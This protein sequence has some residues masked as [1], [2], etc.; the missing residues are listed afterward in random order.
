M[1]RLM[2]A[3]LDTEVGER[4]VGLSGGQA[5]RVALARAVLADRELLLLDEPT[6]QVD[7]ASEAA[8]V[9]ALAAIGAGRTV[10]T[11]SHRAGALIAAN[12]LVRVADGHA[13]EVGDD[14]AAWL[15][16]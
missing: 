8:I 14:T 16:A 9:A 5:Q 13:T 1:V 11:V 7:L 15:P 3:G 4:G 10:V 6:S 12:R 2:P